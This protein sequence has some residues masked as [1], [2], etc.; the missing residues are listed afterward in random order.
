MADRPVIYLFHG[1]DEPAIRGEIEKL[2]ARVG[3]PGVLEMNFTRL[4]GRSLA[5]DDLVTACAAM[6]FLAERR[7]VLLEHPLDQARDEASRKRLLDFLA[8]VPPSTAVVLVHHPG[9]TG[10]RDRREGKI[11]WLE[12]WAETAGERVYLREYNLPGGQSELQAW[13]EKR[14]REYGGE[15]S[16]RAAIRL[17]EL[18]GGE[19]AV[20]DQEIQKLLAYVGWS[21]SIEAEDVEEL[22]VV[23]PETDIFS[24]VDALSNRDGR[25]AV[26]MFHRLLEEQEAR[27][28]FPMIVR[29]FRLLLLVRELQENG[30][31]EVGVAKTLGLHPFVARKV[32]AQA[33]QFSLPMLEAVY[34]RLLEIDI[35][36]KSGEMET[37]LSLDGWIAEFTA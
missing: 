20:L 30:H 13:I 3:G 2:K 1:D 35:A 19:A 32:F 29:Q 4:D 17:A 18:S 37:D 16:G 7:L 24:L 31:G 14:A 34:H 25:A 10:P 36:A 15:F 22:A 5:F 33:R 28:I 26:T 23:I 12:Q 11:H 9:L 8:R 6:P 27:T 21:R